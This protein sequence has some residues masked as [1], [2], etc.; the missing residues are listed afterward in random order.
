MR[1]V[2]HVLRH[3]AHTVRHVLRHVYSDF[4]AI[5]IKIGVLRYVC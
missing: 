3:S 2:P 1:I 5:R 4:Y